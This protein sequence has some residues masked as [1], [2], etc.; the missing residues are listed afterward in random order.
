MVS[1]VV[2]CRCIGNIRNGSRR[3]WY[4]CP[5]HTTAY[6]VWRAWLQLEPPRARLSERLC[7]AV[8]SAGQMI[9][10]PA[11]ASSVDGQ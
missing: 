3:K 8:C 1:G 4:L 6:H 5:T 10:A 9:K 2:Y 11:V 7:Q